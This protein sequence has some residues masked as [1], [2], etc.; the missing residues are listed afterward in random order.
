MEREPA[1]DKRVPHFYLLDAILGVRSSCFLGWLGWLGWLG[2]LLLPGR[3]VMGIRVGRLQLLCC[4]CAVLHALPPRLHAV[5]P[6]G[7]HPPPQMARKNGEGRGAGS[8]VGTIFPRVV[9]AALS[10]LVYLMGRSLE[11][12]Q[13]VGLGGGWVGGVLGCGRGRL[14]S[15]VSGGLRR[16]KRP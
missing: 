8:I 6:A 16:C 5:D 13:K 7:C 15:A 10:Q 3:L 1:A 9:G 12:A 4:T 14:H 11:S 2:C